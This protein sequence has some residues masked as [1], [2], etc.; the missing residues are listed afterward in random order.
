MFTSQERESVYQLLFVDIFY[1]KFIVNLFKSSPLESEPFSNIVLN[2]AY[3]YIDFI[4]CY[5]HL[6]RVL[7]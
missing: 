7:S 2:E 3:L 1:I 5:R 6:L 4:L